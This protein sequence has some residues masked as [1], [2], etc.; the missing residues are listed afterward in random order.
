LTVS[1]IDIFWL[2]MHYKIGAPKTAHNIILLVDG[3]CSWNRDGLLT[4]N[5]F[6]S[7]TSLHQE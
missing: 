2:K 6:T 4:G 1:G 5:K 3:I 7:K